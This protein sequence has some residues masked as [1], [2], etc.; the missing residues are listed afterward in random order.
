[1]IEEEFKKK[2]KK[3]ENHKI[4]DQDIQN[5]LDTPKMIFYLK[6][7]KSFSI[8][9]KYIIYIMHVSRLIC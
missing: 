1:M 3:S 4:K 5:Q 6:K 2:R 9:K 7:K 8:S